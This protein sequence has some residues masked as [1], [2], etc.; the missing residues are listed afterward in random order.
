MGTATSGD[1]FAG[2]VGSDADGHFDDKNATMTMVPLH[3]Q[4]W[5]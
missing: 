5:R 4:E 2:S 1:S 3:S